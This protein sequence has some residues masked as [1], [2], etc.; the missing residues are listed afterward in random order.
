VDFKN[1]LKCLVDGFVK[2]QEL[3]LKVSAQV[4]E[5]LGIPEQRFQMACAQHPEI[6]NFIPH[7]E[8]VGLFRELDLTEL[9]QA[10]L[11]QKVYMEN[12]GQELVDKIKAET[13]DWDPTAKR[14]LPIVVGMVLGDELYEEMGLEDEQI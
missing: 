9:R 7:L 14:M 13:S 1:Y 6:T 8:P 3:T 10:I 12:H 4:M 11:F 2:M 5:S